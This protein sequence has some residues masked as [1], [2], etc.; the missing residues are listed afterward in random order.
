MLYQ[1]MGYNNLNLNKMSTDELKKHK[2]IMESMYQKNSVKPG[3][4]GYK[5]DVQKDF[6]PSA[7]NEWDMDDEDD[8]DIV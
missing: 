7:A 3:D 8:Y 2:Q 1:K 4:A 5:Y 6:R